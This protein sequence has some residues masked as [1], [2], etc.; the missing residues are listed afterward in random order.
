MTA[1]KAQY[2]VTVTTEGRQ[3]WLRRTVWTSDPERADRH[4]TLDAAVAA[5]GRAKPFMPAKVYRQAV[6]VQA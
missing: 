3:F 1:S 4:D 5:L 6:A 2:V